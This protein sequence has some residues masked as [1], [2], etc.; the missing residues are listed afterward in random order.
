MKRSA[1]TAAAAATMGG[2]VLAS[3]RPASAANDSV[4]IGVAS[5]Y[6]TYSIFFATKELGYYKDANLD[7]DIQTFRGGPASLEA[8]A[9]GAVDLC[10]IL[11]TAAALA[12]QKGVKAKIV[13]MYVPV[14]ASGW[15]IM[16]PSDSPI[17]TAADL[18]GKTVGVTQIGSLTDFWTQRVTKDAGVTVTS[19]PLGG[20][21]EAGLRS[22]KVDAAILWPL[23]SYKGIGH[24]DLRPIINLHNAL[25]PTISE[26]VA[27]SD[28]IMT[29][30]PDVLRR[31]LAATSRGLIYM[32]Q[33][34]SW[35]VSFLKKYFDDQDDKAVELVYSDFLK[36][37]DPSG[38]MHGD[39]QKTSLSLAAPNI[40]ASLPPADQVFSSAFTPI[41]AH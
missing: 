9:A 30:R 32:Q 14:R 31:W 7:V 4:K 27:A 17:K 18:N 20:G 33:H 26:G 40:V 6:P 35:T 28:E 1:F 16:V 3:G 34:E 15:Y 39:W 13:A 22:K 38:S 8:L 2:L 5:V 19:V 37:I 11:P 23:G 24:G 12:V 36:S 10:T 41:K 21:V 29:K 25:G